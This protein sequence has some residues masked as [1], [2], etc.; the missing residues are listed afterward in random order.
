[1]N[2]KLVIL[3]IALALEASPAVALAHTAAV[4][5]RS[6]RADVVL[7]V[8]SAA[9]VFATGW[10]RLRRRA[11]LVARSPRLVLYLA[12][13]AALLVALVSPIDALAE[14]RLSMHM[15]Q[16]LLLM[17]AAPLLVLLADPFACFLWA[18]A[19]S[20]RKSVGKLFVRGSR[21]RHLLRALT[22]MPVAW[23]VYVIDLWAWHHPSM[24]QLALENRF[25]HDLQHI[26][27]FST[28]LLFWWPIVN[29]A[30]RFRGVPSHGLRIVYLVA[31]T[32]QNTLLG[33][34]ISLPERVLYPFYERVPGLEALSPINDQA[35]GGGIMWVSGHM[36]LIPIL[37]LVYRLLKSEEEG[38]QSAAAQPASPQVG[39]RPRLEERFS[40]T[41]QAAVES[42]CRTPERTMA[43]LSVESKRPPSRSRSCKWIPAAG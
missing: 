2:K 20:T 15:V 42:G 38:A 34:A 16:H 17:M 6:F 4:S 1:M 37:F 8:A 19:G 14:Q 35:L 32:L 30:P 22:S 5:E 3:V 33:M 29:P 24:Y 9:I 28:S 40:A 23:A 41:G 11:P 43:N 13:L 10:Y 21:L 25:V 27:F 36:Y 31:A 12:G 18:L 26:L 7:V 39:S